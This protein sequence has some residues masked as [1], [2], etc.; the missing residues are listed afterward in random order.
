MTWLCVFIPL[1]WWFTRKI[2]PISESFG[3]A[4]SHSSGVLADIAGNMDAVRSFGQHDNER[5]RFRES[6]EEEK[7]ASLRVRWFLII[8]NSG[9]YGGQILFQA[10]FMGLAVFA[11]TQG[12]LGIAELVMV[13]SLSA[14]LLTSVWGLTQHLQGFYDQSGILKATLN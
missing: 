3:E 6:L 7:R 10:T 8:M 13:S 1:S 12:Q 5:F 11:H 2:L 4:A 9:L 14:I